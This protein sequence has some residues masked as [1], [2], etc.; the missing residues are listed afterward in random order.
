MRG[1]FVGCVRMTCHVSDW[2]RF[3]FIEGEKQ[4]IFHELNEKLTKFVMLTVV[5]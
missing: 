1:D 4:E 2:I 3:D 5:F